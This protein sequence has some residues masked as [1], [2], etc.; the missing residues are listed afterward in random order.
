MTDIELT[1]VANSL[2]NKDLATL[3]GMVA[4]RLMVFVDLGDN[5][6][7]QLDVTGACLN[8]S[9]VQLNAPK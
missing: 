5:S 6:G 4:H 8:G 1:S 7:L 9:A 2:T 3:L